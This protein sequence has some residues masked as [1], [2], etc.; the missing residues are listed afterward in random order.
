[1]RKVVYLPHYGEFGFLIMNH[2]RAVHKDEADVKIVCCERG[3]ECLFPSASG[4]FYD[5]PVLQ[6]EHRGGDTSDWKWKDCE[7]ANKRLHQVLPQF[8]PD[9]EIVQ[10][11]YESP[12]NLTDSIKFFPKVAAELP[13]VDV[14]LGV[15][16]RTF[17]PEKNWQ[18][19]EHLADLL[20]SVGLTVGL[21]GTKET[22]NDIRADA[23]SWD[24]SGGATAGTVDLLSHCRLYVGTDTGTS[25]LAA[26]M[27][28]PQLTFRFVG[29]LQGNDDFLP[30]MERAN[31]R[32]FRRLAD[33]VWDR[34]D[35]VTGAVIRNLRELRTCK[36]FRPDPWNIGDWAA[37]PSLYFPISGADYDVRLDNLS[38]ISSQVSIVGGGGLLST[39]ERE[40][41]NLNNRVVVWGAG[42][43]DHGETQIRYPPWLERCTLV[44]VRDYGTRLRWVPCA[45][46]MST[47]FNKYRSRQPE[48]EAV[49]YRHGLKWLD[50]IPQQLELP[51]LTNQESSFENVLSFLASA[52]VVI[53]SSYHGAYWATLLGRK[54]IA[55]P[56][57]S[58]FYAF[59]HPPILATGEQ[60]NDW[61]SLAGD[62]TTYSDALE[63]CR[64]VNLAFYDDVKRI[65]C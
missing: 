32:Y 19:W 42:A 27:D 36:V 26:L 21:V 12:W 6:D 29:Q 22:S 20:Q 9:Y 56:F 35:E 44:G 31:R 2:L 39:Y 61:R 46:C 49:V 13:R 24:H 16:K 57:S 15:R 10:L 45:S 65:I 63:E 64:T 48:Q 58:K 51:T 3:N 1:M 43:N 4:F 11:K 5:Y 55:A 18:H 62:C 37:R 47:L 28:V 30:M 34:P 8:Y 23:R 50:T 40:L 54:V 38:D 41:S 60:L 14:A 7:E 52:A 17:C 59:R 53:T 25:H 33:S